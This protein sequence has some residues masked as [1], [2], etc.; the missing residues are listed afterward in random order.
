MSLNDMKPDIVSGMLLQRLN[1][2]S[3]F[4]QVANTD[5]EGEITQ[6]G[7]SVRILEIGPVTIRTYT[8]G[9]TSAIT[10]EHLKDASKVLQIN[11]S[12]YYAFT[13]DDADSAQARVKLLND[14]ITQSAWGLRDELDAFIAGLRTDAGIA[15]GGTAATGA[16]I[17][18]TN[19]LTYF[20]EAARRLDET[21]TPL[22]TRWCVGPAWFTR[23]A[24]LAGIV[25]LTDNGSAFR[26]GSVGRVE[27]FDLFTS[28]NVTAISG[29]DRFPVLFGYR[30]SISM[31]VQVLSS[32]VV[33]PSTRFVDLAKGLD[34]YGAKVVRPNNLGVLY[35]DYT[36]EAT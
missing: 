8:P 19:I 3:V 21:N 25:Q 28:N 16:D 22:D 35:A 34:L 24:G 20:M 4:V 15:V 13:L 7:Q 27:G 17:T 5:Y 33:R 11:R 36:A 1:D 29:T 14:G 32:E 26:E 18:S 6:Y 30:G 9:G 12:R 2:A 23:K 31:A 10:L